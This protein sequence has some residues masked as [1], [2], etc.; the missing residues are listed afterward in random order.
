MRLF[1]SRLAPALLRERATRLR[2]DIAGPQSSSGADAGQR[3]RAPQWHH[4]S[5]P[6]VASSFIP[7]REPSEFAG[8][9]PT[10]IGFA[11]PGDFDEIPRAAG[12]PDQGELDLIAR[13]TSRY[14]NWVEFGPQE[15]CFT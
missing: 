11:F 14:M 10:H 3:P 13:F 5:G 12:S 8:S 1:N 2:G 15:R 4:R 7:L 6:G 9:T